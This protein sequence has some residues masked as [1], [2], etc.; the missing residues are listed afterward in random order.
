M[1]RNDYLIKRKFYTYLL[2]AVMMAA[3]MQLGNLVDSILVG[4]FLGPSALSAMNLGM[5]VVFIAQVPL[6]I[7]MSGGA[8]VCSISLGNRDKKQADAILSSVMVVALI[9]NLVFCAIGLLGA[10]PIAEL[11]S[12]G[13]SLAEDTTDFI[14]VYL[15]GM[16]I[17]GLGMILAAFMGVD[18][19][20]GESAALHVTANVVNLLLDVVFIKAFD[21]GVFGAALS[22]VA[23]YAVALIIFGILYLR[24]KKRM[25]VFVLSGVRA[26]LSSF[27]AIFKT[28]LS[29]G[30]LVV[31]NALQLFVL[32]AGIL[33]VTGEDGMAIYAVVTNSRFLVQ[34]VLNGMVMVIPNIAGVLLGEKDYYGI[35]RLLSR[36]V[37]IS[38]IA[39]AALT[40]FFLIAPSVVSA[41]FGFNIA[42]LQ[43]LMET[44]LR[45][46]AISFVFYA[47]NL[48]IQ[49]YYSTLQ[50][51]LL[52]NLDTVLQGL[53]VLIPVTLLLIRPCGVAGT[54][55]GAVIAEVAAFGIVTL[56][57][58][59]FQKKG[60]LPGK[61]MA[62]LPEAPEGRFVDVTIR[63]TKEEA[64]SLAHALIAYCEE[65]KIDRS[66]ANAIAVSAEE[67]VANISDYGF[68]ETGRSYID[69]CLSRWDDTLI[70]RIRDDGTF[71]NPLNYERE[72]ADDLDISG[73]EVVKALADR[74]EYTRVL[75]MNNT[76]VEVSLTSFGRE[77]ASC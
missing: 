32:N 74:L 29:Q 16:P 39:G 38:L 66:A 21:M 4:N 22:T 41:L 64:A 73:L 62:A 23:G 43:G 77:A 69:V 76:V 75:N 70:L 45:I 47:M 3:A 35:R 25:L 67:L 10:E 65:E 7:F 58:V 28:G 11:L 17:L 61:D 63:D 72:K 54:S 36:V 24:S 33:A 8:A 53:V 52:A 26:G 46:Y 30:M 27:G 56:L 20:P 18:N 48:T 1:Q 51:P 6:M 37:R 55:I 59:I 19:H 40:V 49:Y 5:P 34:L 15:A 14:R 60:R 13:G 2:P 42:E 12:D 9:I 68:K 71:F 50:R 44:C 31:M 57:R